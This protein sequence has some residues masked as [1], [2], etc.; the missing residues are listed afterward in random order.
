[1]SLLEELEAYSKAC[2]AD[3]ACCCVKHRWACMRFL[4]DVEHA[5]T[6]DLPYVFDEARAERF[7]AWARL[8]KHTKGI[9]AGEPI[10]LAPIQR[11]IFG[12]VFGWVHRET[13]LRRFRRAYWQVGRKNAKSQSLALV[14]DYLL[15]ADGEP[16][17]EVYIGATKKAQAEIIY[18]ETVAMLRRS[19]EFFR[20]KWHEKYSIITRSLR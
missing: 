1:M 12:N 2:I 18:K 7:Y 20:G 10:E 15:M 5:G 9:L 16:M 13:G 19:P 8:H 14:G 17:S 11:F 6:D 4:R 3:A